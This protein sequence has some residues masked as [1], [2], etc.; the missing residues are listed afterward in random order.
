MSVPLRYNLPISA[1]HY[2]IISGAPH[3][4]RKLDFMPTILVILQLNEH[5]YLPLDY[6]YSTPEKTTEEEL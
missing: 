5:K 3:R 1:S 4:R 6:L 2:T